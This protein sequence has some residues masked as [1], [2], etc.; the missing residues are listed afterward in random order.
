MAGGPVGIIIIV[1]HRIG[2]AESQDVRAASRYMKEIEMLSSISLRP[3]IDVDY[4]ICHGQ[5]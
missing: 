2:S 1:N 4:W 5:Q 3:E